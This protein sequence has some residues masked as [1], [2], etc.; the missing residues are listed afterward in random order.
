MHPESESVFFTTDPKT[1]D[2]IASNLQ[3]LGTLVGREATARE[4][5]AALQSRIAAL[6]REYANRRVIAVFY[7]I[8]PSPLYTI[9]GAHLIKM[10]AFHGWLPAL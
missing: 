4:A 2:G 1:I 9:G 3:R 10:A 5:A 7:E 6:R 8:W